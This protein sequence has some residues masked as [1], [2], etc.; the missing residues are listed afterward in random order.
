[1]QLSTPAA[2][3]PIKYGMRELAKLDKIMTVQESQV[4]SVSAERG[5]MAEYQTVCRVE[6]L[7]SGEAK[8]VEVAGKLVALFAAEGSYFA[9]DD[10]C[11]HMGGSLSDGHVENGIVTCPWHGWRFRLTDGAWA[12][13]PRI[14]TGS[15]P[16]RVLDGNIQVL[17]NGPP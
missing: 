4:Q 13:N 1:L 10:V 5:W 15:Y 2:W 3:D 7:A 12:D 6:D 9:I 16:V 8:M 11:P 14:K 17:V